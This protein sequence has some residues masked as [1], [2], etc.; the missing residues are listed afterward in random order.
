MGI[1]SY[2]IITAINTSLLPSLPPPPQLVNVADLGEPELPPPVRL[3]QCQPAPQY[4]GTPGGSWAL[5]LGC[6]CTAPPLRP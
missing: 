3:P 6:V 4:G 5:A 2:C 1:F